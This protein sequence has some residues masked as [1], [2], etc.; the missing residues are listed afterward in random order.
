M[1]PHRT[2]LFDPSDDVRIQPLCAAC[3]ERT[4]VLGQGRSAEP[5]L[6]FKVV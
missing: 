2:P 4:V 6:G 5:L 1:A 3:T